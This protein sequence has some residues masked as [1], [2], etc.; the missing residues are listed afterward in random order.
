MR[1]IEI[2]KRID[3]LLQ[4]EP[5]L[6]NSIDVVNLISENQDAHQ[7]FFTV[8]DERWLDWLWL[9]G[10]L[11]LIK[12]AP[13]NSE[14]Y[15]LRTPEISYLVRVSEKVPEKIAD[16]ILTEDLA[17]TKE[18][19]RPELIDQ[20][21]RMCEHLPQIQLARVV[22]K[23][24]QQEWVKIMAPY[25]RWG[26]EYEKIFQ[27]LVD[28]K[29]YDTLLLLA[30]TVLSIRDKEESKDKDYKF[31][32]S[33]PFY[34]NELSYTKVFEHVANVA[35]DK[36]E[37][38]LSL[39]SKILTKIV[40]LGGDAEADEV[41]PIHDS[42]Y[43]FD[44]DFFTLELDSKKPLSFRDDVRELMAVMKSL[45]DRL[46]GG[47]CQNPER[48]RNY[49]NNYVAPLPNSRAMWRLRLYVLSLC[50]DAFARELRS[51]FFRLFQVER[52]HEIMS[53]TEYEKA[54][55]KGFCTLSQEDKNLYVDSAVTYFTRKE[56][57]NPD[58]NWHIRHGSEIF[59]MIHTYLTQAQKEL[60]TVSGFAFLKDYQPIP[61]ISEVTSG[62][63]H[64]R[65]PITQEEFGA[66]SL[67]EIAQKLRAEWTPM[68]LREAYKSDD[69]L[70]PRNAEGVGDL[71][72]NDIPK[73][74]QDY[75]TNA[76]LFFERG[77][78]DEHYTYAFFR[79]LE[80]AIKNNRPLAHSIDWS[81][82]I[83]LF[84]AI[85]QSGTAEA[86]GGGRRN[87]EV[88][89]A[90]LAGWNGVH[91]GIADVLQILL[92][93]DNGVLPIDFETHRKSIF[94]T[95]A[96]VLTYPDPIPQDEESETAT[97]KTSSGGEPQLV[98]DPFT[99]A[100]NAVRGR[101]FQAFVL[102]I[103]PDGK[104]FTKDAEVRISDDVKELYERTLDAE[105][106]RAI[107]FMFGHYL[108]QF[109]FRNEKWIQGLLSKIFPEVPENAHLYLASWEGYLSNNLYREMFVDPLFEKLYLR[110]VAIEDIKEKNRRYFRDP[111]EGIATHIALAF[112]HYED[113]RFEHPLFKEFWEKGSLEQ[114]KE[115][116]SFLGRSVV[117]GDNAQINEFLKKE[118]TV[119]NLLESFW[120]WAL[121]TQTEPG[122]FLEFGFWSNIEKGLFDSVWLAERIRK[123]LEKTKGVFDWDYGLT[124]ISVELAEKAPEDMLK[125]TR[126]FFVD[127]GIKAGHQR[128]PY[129]VEREWF[130]VFKTLLQN[131][132]TKEST[133]DLINELI[134]DGGSPF[135]GLKNL[136]E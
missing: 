29:D 95:I 112:L 10:F 129:Y 16:I 87:R 118:S 46:I 63:V 73:R 38:A 94:D 12:E 85:T 135:W 67:I 44:V 68:Q 130:D 25:N 48:V 9:N 100:I 43:L 59:S 110:G 123:T 93:E 5:I 17:T 6:A 20:I 76:H 32:S 134:R 8:A 57:E 37:S 122:L 26:F 15:G 99:M 51:A 84:V 115:F 119:K 45:V 66:L 31:G 98:S 13:S 131:P 24:H 120:D 102:F 88:G 35:D 96:Y 55:E 54:L 14:S 47:D 19:F 50:P 81:N 125:I 64:T 80:E 136:V 75:I 42:F 108:P 21:L 65:G 4:S 11:D 101:A 111:D 41:F 116:V 90:W 22:P 121:E 82:L 86:F 89:D 105:N 70:N 83:A 74:L 1:Q 104:K 33:N 97:M 58:Q 39:V 36:A 128:R 49:Y 126:L 117:S 18:K 114:H 62:T 52:Y 91:S 113:A 23:I 34:F 7:Y 69:F 133:V 28:A 60:I 103:Y 2:H 92:K 109:Y 72:R 107:M 40:I 61:S 106:T 3:T 79:G 132:K 77:V 30:E 56:K 27:I 127:G 71:I 78:L 124:K 53:D